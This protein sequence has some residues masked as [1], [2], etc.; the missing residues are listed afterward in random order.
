MHNAAMPPPRSVRPISLANLRGFE[1]SARLLSFTLAAEELHL[2]QS[3]IS[4]QIRSLEGQ[5]GKPL[6]RRRIRH[7]ELTAAGAVNSAV[8]LAAIFATPL[9]GWLSDRLAR[10]AT[11][12]AA[13]VLLLPVALAS[14]A[15]GGLPLWLGTLAIGV[16]YSLVPRCCGRSRRSWSRASDWDP[17]SR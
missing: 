13:G 17:R 14:M 15:S 3:S 9:F 12:L 7:L 2:T 6:F 11:L 16:S 8:Y 4:R 1:A 10:P 5:V